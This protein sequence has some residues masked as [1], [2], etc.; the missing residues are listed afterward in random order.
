MPLETEAHKQELQSSSVLQ[1]SLQFKEPRSN[2]LQT[3]KHASETSLVTLLKGKYIDVSSA[4]P[5]NAVYTEIKPRISVKVGL[6]LEMQKIYINTH[7]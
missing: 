6:I 2:I 5:Q 1:F 4:I 3:G 7:F